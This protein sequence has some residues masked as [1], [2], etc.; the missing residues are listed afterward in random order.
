MIKSSSSLHEVQRRAARDEIERVAVDL[1]LER[2]YTATTVDDV[3]ATAGVSRGMGFRYFETKEDLVLA[4]MRET[5][6]HLAQV[7][8]DLP[9]DVGPWSAITETLIGFTGQLDADAARSRPRALLLLETP[10]LHAALGVK[11][12]EWRNLISEAVLPRV[13]GGPSTRC[14]RAE[15]LTAAALACLDVAVAAWAKSTGGPSA[16]TRL[17]TSLQALRD[18]DGD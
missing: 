11:H 12:L 6:D 16:T 15:T 18:Q 13:R 7:L 3:A 17:K 4:S 1:F 5:G 10:A 9:N 14:I 8:L 2:G